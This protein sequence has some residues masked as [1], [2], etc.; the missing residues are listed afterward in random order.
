MRSC[1][2]HA[3]AERSRDVVCHLNVELIKGVVDGL[4]NRTLDVAFE[5]T[6]GECCVKLRTS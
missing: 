4:G 2:Y 5:P 6:S 1:P 3:L